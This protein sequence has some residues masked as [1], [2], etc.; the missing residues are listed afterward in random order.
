MTISIREPSDIP[1]SSSTVYVQPRT[2]QEQRECWRVAMCAG[3]PERMKEEA[4]YSREINLETL[5]AK[6]E[7]EK[8]Q[9]RQHAEI[10]IQRLNNEDRREERKHELA[11]REI[12]YNME[13]LQYERAF[14]SLPSNSMLDEQYI[15][16][17]SQAKEE[18]AVQHPAEE[19]VVSSTTDDDGEDEEDYCRRIN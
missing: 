16:H 13:N 4:I 6:W 10:E 5:K 8:I 19:E 15:R 2:W 7:L 1:A 11:L 9:T 14:R 3:D 18:V 17:R 12:Q